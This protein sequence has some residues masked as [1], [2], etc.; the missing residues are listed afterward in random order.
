MTATFTVYEQRNHN[1]A[2]VHRATCRCIRIHGAEAPIHRV[3]TTRALRRRNPP[4]P[5]PKAL[6]AMSGSA[7]RVGHCTV[8]KVVMEIGRRF[9]EP[10][11]LED[12]TKFKA[13]AFHRSLSEKQCSK[14]Y[15]SL[16]ECKD[17]NYSTSQS[18]VL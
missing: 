7:R 17:A 5:S 2:S 3:N 4:G 8:K 11:D 13:C 6:I 9:V 18:R 16:G 10:K 1:Y 12:W 15:A 14:R